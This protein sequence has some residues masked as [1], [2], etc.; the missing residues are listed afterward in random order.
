M[1]ASELEFKPTFTSQNNT[2]LDNKG[3]YESASESED[4]DDA[5][6]DSR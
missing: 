2:I 6:L 1:R 3:A 5:N 4:F